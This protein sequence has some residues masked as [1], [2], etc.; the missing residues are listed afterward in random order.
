[1]KKISRIL[2]IFGLMLLAISCDDLLE[3]D[4]VS[5]LGYDSFWKSE[6]AAKSSMVGVHGLMR[7]WNPTFW[8][9]GEVRSDMWGGKGFESEFN[10]ELITQ[11]ISTDKAPWNSWANIYIT[12]KNKSYNLYRLINQ[13]NDAIKNIPLITFQ[14]EAEKKFLMGQAYGMRAYVYYAMLRTWG[15]IPVVLEPTEAIDFTNL[16]R[17]RS[18][19]Q[20]VMNQIKQDIQASLTA[21]GDNNGF[22]KNQRV[23]WSKAA[24]QI[25]KGDVF[26][27][28]GTHMGAGNNDYSQAKDALQEVANRTDLGLLPDFSNVFAYTNKNNKEIIFAYSYALEQ[29]TNN[30]NNFTA[31]QSDISNL[32]DSKGNKMGTGLAL[33]GGNR[34]HPSD[35][36][37]AVL[38]ENPLDQRGE[39]TFIRLFKNP[40]ATDYQG[41]VIKKFS[42]VVDAGSRKMVDDV[43]VYRYADALLLLAEAKNLL[44]EDPSPEINQIR[45]RAYGSSYNALIHGYVKGSK[46]VNTEAI[47]KESQKEFAA[48]G[49]RWWDLRRAGNSYVL[50]YNKYLKAGEEYKLLAPISRDM[51][52]RNPLLTQTPGYSN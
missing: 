11:D 46:A 41:S 9:M 38:F 45:A 48:E 8:E 17:K 52:G 35:E 5:S 28:S 50:K 3:I 31:R 49:K 4:R 23:Y 27:W 24:T 22:H 36:L 21:F 26:I 10:M 7:W 2:L 44:G 40:N 6:E 14:N 30:Y 51:I 39:A 12:S 47:L 37:L 1:M 33:I 15:G 16:G 18:S 13:I 32:Y 29:A 42:G 19:E 43:P 25:L 20:E 34:H